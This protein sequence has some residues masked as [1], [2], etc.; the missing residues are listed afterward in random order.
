MK[1]E[2]PSLRGRDF[3][4]QGCYRQGSQKPQNPNRPRSVVLCFLENTTKEE[5]L[6]AAWK[7]KDISLQGRKITF[8]FDYQPEVYRRIK[9]Y[10]SIPKY[11]KQRG[12]RCRTDYCGQLRV[13]FSPNGERVTYRDAEQARMDLETHGFENVPQRIEPT[14]EQ[15]GRRLQAWQEKEG[16]RAWQEKNLCRIRAGLQRVMEKKAIRA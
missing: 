15:G 1:E 3:R 7:K 13:T 12:H 10:G 9:D 6:S 4:L 16:R 8:S 5:V 11:L 14:T 2:L